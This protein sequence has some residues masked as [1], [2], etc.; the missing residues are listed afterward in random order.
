MPRLRQ[1][2]DQYLSFVSLESGLFTLGLPTSYLDL[3][4]PGARDT[5]VE[6][7]VAAVVDGLFSMLVTAGVV[8]IIRCPKARFR[9]RHPRHLFFNH[10]IPGILNLSLLLALHKDVLPS[11][12]AYTSRMG[13]A[14]HRLRPVYVVVLCPALAS[15]LVS[16]KALQLNLM[17]KTLDLNP[18]GR[19]RPARGHPARVQAAGS[20]QVPEQSVQRG[21]QRACGTP[22]EA[23][24]VPV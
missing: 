18:A 1:V 3:N 15:H 8:P 20:P 9:C 12:S 13:P 2:F 4:D 23:A 7:A 10:Q 24:V 11:M 22:G 16:R 21:Q 19:R 6:A 5:Q 17:F 14:R